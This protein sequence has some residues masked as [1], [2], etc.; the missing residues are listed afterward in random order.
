MSPTVFPP[1]PPYYAVIFTSQRSTVADG[2]GDMADLMVTLAAQQPGFLGIDSA[3]GSDGLGMTVSYW[4]SLD[5]IAAW[6]NHSEHQLAQQ[7]GRAQ[8][9]SRYTLQVALVVRAHGW[10]AES[11]MSCSSNAT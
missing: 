9:Y 5:D 1:E 6:R 7:L 2:Y 10:Q 8:W 3:R 4:R 11:A